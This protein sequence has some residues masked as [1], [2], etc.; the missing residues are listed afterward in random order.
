MYIERHVTGALYYQ[1]GTWPSSIHVTDGDYKYQLL[2][3]FTDSEHIIIESVDFISKDAPDTPYMKYTKHVGTS[4]LVKFLTYI[5]TIII[6]S[7]Y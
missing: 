3:Q 5:Y 2:L 1:E 7:I 4:K 6:S